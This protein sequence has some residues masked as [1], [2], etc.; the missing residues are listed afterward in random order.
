MVWEAEEL[1]RAFESAAREADMYFGDPEV[2]VET[3]D[4]EYSIPPGKRNPNPSAPGR[5]RRTTDLLRT[6]WA[7]VRY[8]APT[9][10]AGRLVRVLSRQP[11]A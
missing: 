8:R 1:E 9:S 4:A 10:L 2:Y 11:A 7:T 6:G 5:G 3:R